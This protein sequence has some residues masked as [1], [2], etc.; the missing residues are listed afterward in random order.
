MD[1][2]H[3]PTF[4][5]KQVLV[6][7]TPLVFISIVLLTYAI[8]RLW[9]KRQ[10]SWDTEARNDLTAK[11]VY[12][13]VLFI[14][15]VFPLVSAVII[16]TFAYD[17]RLGAGSSY[18]VADYS[19]E[20]SDSAHQAYRAYACCMAFLYCSGVPLI[21]LYCLHCKKSQIHQLQR[22]EE[23]VLH[24]DAKT[25]HKLDYA[26]VWKDIEGCPKLQRLAPYVALQC[27][28]QRLKEDDPVL[29]GM[30]PLYVTTVIFFEL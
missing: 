3:L 18:L 20:R 27:R 13:T 15:T 19:I 24:L 11:C 28:L 6:T 5:T 14:Y 16:Q 2:S 21:S 23:A 25:T 26:D 4:L 10:D 29:K 8:N 22:I 1:L 7:T 12:V 30:S 17:A 9:L